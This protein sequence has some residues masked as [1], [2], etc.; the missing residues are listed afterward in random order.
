MRN[1]F[2]D[3]EVW[4]KAHQLTLQ[5]YKLTNKFPKEETKYHLLLA[6]DLKYVDKKNYF[7][8]QEMCEEVGKM[9]YGLTKSLSS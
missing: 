4:N 8:A 5:I 2:E 9:L 6:Y 1:K 7:G 3:L